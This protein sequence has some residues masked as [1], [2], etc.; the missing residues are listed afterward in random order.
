MAA[1]NIFGRETTA[2]QLPAELRAILAEMKRERVAFEALTSAARDSGQSL[3]Q[4]LQP[5]T[6]AQKVVAE[7]QARVKSLERLVP[8]LATLDEQTENVSK[9]QRRTETQLSQNADSAKQLRSEVDELRGVLE[10]ALALK[11][12][13]AGF[14]ELGGGFKA[15]R[16]DADTLSGA[17]RELTQGFDQVRARQEEL[18]KTSDAVAARFSAFEDRQHEVQRS[19]A[20][21]ESRTATVGQTLKDL[22]AAA[23][24]AAQTK[25]QLTTLKALAES[26]S[27]KVTALEGQREVVER[28][29]SQVGKL[30]ELMSEVD[31]KIRRHEESAKGLQDLES[32]VGEL[33]G[34]HDEVLERSTEITANHES[35]KQA[36]GELRARLAGLRDDVQRAVKRFEL[37]N[38][39]LDAV[40]QRIL[41]L[42]GGLTAMEGRFK[43]L[44]ES[45]RSITDVGSKADGLATQLEGIAENVAMLGTQAERVRAIEASTSRIGNTVEEMSQRVAQLEKSHPSVQAALEDVMALRG[46][47]ESV[48]GALEQVEGAA[49]EMARVLE[50]QSGTKAWLSGVTDQIKALRVE[51]GAIEDL[52]PTVESVRSEADR[53]S[54]AMGQIDA[55]SRLVEDLNKRLSDLA[56]LGGQLDERSRELVSRMQGADERFAALTARADESA[57]IEKLVPA[58]V[59]TVER[60]ERRVGDV[61]TA[62]TALESRAHNL[63]GLAERTRALGQEL[64]LKQTAL[65]K[66]TEHLDQVAQLR[67][68][69]ASAA[70]QL[71]ERSSKLGTAVSTAGNRLLELTA[72]VDELDNRAGGLRF[73]QK[74]M[75]QFEERLA[76]WE[77]VE[78]Q[79]TRALEQMN[80]RQATV[81]AMQADM[82]RLYEVA[83]KTTDDVRSIASARE[84]VGQTRATLE[85][86]LSMMTHVHDAANTLDHRKRQ[87]EQAE[88]RLARAE[89][90]LAEI[91]TGLAQLFGQKALLDQAATQAGSLEF[92]TKQAEAVMAALKRERETSEKVRTVV[93][94]T[95]ELRRS[96]ERPTKKSA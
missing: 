94:P 48:R 68:Q 9:T 57:R 87:V 74:R 19:V 89:T 88:E 51:L 6:D 5:I 43:L 64:E 31:A 46:T 53:V 29:T 10:Q 85:T 2:E 49:D 30:H 65:D 70:Q 44:E 52:K 93:A 26:V 3:T 66:A 55:R 4:L 96:E 69:A 91:Q 59:A 56:T 95:P 12:D 47:H 58:A 36:D 61:D 41:D 17:V 92:H 39:G 28:A 7:L 84:E 38:Q 23:A 73:A 14:L 27:D 62:V 83:E 42:R 24:E 34:L 82:H 8:V 71:E 90:L 72:M 20:D 1:W 80:Q 33:K 35:V 37:E 11:N 60:A 32:K 13:V 86:V 25:R 76:K 22:S 21:T 18:R 16:M 67:E 40:G 54:Q 15:L 63:E 75:A 78:S 77:A 81:D 79:L 50:Q 45:S